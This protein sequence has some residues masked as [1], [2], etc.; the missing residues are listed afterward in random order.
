M[1]GTEMKYTNLIQGRLAKLEA[2]TNELAH[3]QASLN[4]KQGVNTF[5]R[6]T[7]PNQ[8]HGLNQTQ[9]TL[10][11][12]INNLNRSNFNESLSEDYILFPPTRHD[13]SQN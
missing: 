1:I 11:R 3:E 13:S 10:N 5:N 2:F 9:T 12:P 6:S 8:N 4:A 7:L